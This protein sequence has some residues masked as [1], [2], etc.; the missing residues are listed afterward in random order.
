MSSSP[1]VKPGD[2]LAGKY[3]VERVLGAGG[4]GYVVAA[5]HLQLDQ[6]VAMKFLRKGAVENT[7]AGARFLR[8]AKAVVKLRNEHVAKVY[9][10]GT[11]EGGEPYI[12]MEYLEGCDLAALAKQRHSVPA[13]EAAEYVM[14]ACEALAEAHALG[15]VHRDIKLANLFV[16]RGPAGGP[17][18]KVLDFGISKTN[19]F[20][21]SEHEMT[22]TASMLG[23]PRFMSPEQMRDPR[24]VDG[25]T[26][27][28]SLGVVLYRLVAGRPPFEADTLGRLLTM[29]MHEQEAPLSSVRGDLPPGFDQVVARCL[30]KDPATRFSTVAELA[31]A[32]VPYTLDPARAR[33]VA[34][35]I[36]AVQS[37]PTLPPI[38]ADN[39]GPLPAA[40]GRVSA[41]P[42]IADTGTASPWTGT[43]GGA[44]PKSPAT[45]IALGVALA[46][47]LV[48][49]G[50]FA[51]VRDDRQQASARAAAAAMT[52]QPPAPPAPTLTQA[53]VA[54]HV[55]PTDPTAV[56][57]ILGASPMTPPPPATG[58]PNA[59]PA[60]APRRAPVVVTPRAKAPAARPASTPVTPKNESGI[61]DT[62]D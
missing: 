27:V 55:E 25:R 5:R 2:V 40:S 60:P 28:W 48:G 52:I 23:S 32:L 54:P 35:R 14:Q 4:M 26:D 24:A 21:E 41:P 49:A 17:L 20:G 31:Y 33:S 51:K 13:S 62:R 44:R 34:D 6:M 29:V 12:V 22:R 18:V 11:L 58:V 15:I 59:E 3:R 9:D 37:L 46:A 42:A 47:I 53:P 45:T 50:I 8:E 56:A 57:T 61:P 1:S 30:Q 43:H 39:S 36:A 38:T 7:E 19:P 10:V 16:T